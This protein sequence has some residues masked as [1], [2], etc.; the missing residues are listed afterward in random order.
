MIAAFIFA[1]IVHGR[2]VF[3]HEALPGVEVT[4]GTSKVLTDIDGRYAFK[5]VAPGRY[6]IE[7]KLDGF[8]A[9]REA[10][11][12]RSEDDDLH[13]R[14]LAV[15]RTLIDDDDNLVPCETEHAGRWGFP[16]CTD[17]DL[18]SA[19]E[20]SVT[21]GDHSAVRLLQQRYET[22][23]NVEER[24]RIAGLLLRNVADDSK[25]WNDITH[26]AEEE[27]RFD[28][29]KEELKAFCAKNG[30]EASDYELVTSTAFMIASED[31]RSNALMRRALESHSSL[32]LVCAVMGLAAQRDDSALQAIDTMLEREGDNARDV[33]LCL[34]HYRTEAAD[35]I[36]AKHLRVDD[37]D[38]YA[39][40]R[41][42]HR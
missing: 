41:E 40:V 35:A 26:F 36:A 13:D 3:E 32:T 12:V 17:Y 21:N 42:L 10:L 30:I 34:A 9:E 11:F 14:S 15:V 23:T 29:R 16:S 4:L 5:D 22:Q 27:L 2:V 38:S 33:V 7:Y 37:R 1:A 24:I 6:D 39:T 25:Y 18:D 28:G 8:H 19:L 31:R 20:T